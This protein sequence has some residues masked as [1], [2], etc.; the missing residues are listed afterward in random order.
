MEYYGDVKIFC[1]SI[2]YLL[3]GH[4]NWKKALVSVS[5]HGITRA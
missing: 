3:I 1:T 4:I 2:Y 5:T